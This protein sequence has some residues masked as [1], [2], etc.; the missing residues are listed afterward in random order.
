MN[1]FCIN[2]YKENKDSEN[3]DC[4]AHKYFGTIRRKE[5]KCPFTKDN[6]TYEFPYVGDNSNCKK[7]LIVRSFIGSRYADGV[8]RDFKP[9][10]GMKRSLIEIARENTKKLNFDQLVQNLTAEF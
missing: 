6:L 7:E 8:C 9:L 1:R 4:K 2:Q 3:W 5:H 10:R